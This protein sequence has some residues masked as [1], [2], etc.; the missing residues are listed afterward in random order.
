MLDD[1]HNGEPLLPGN[2]APG[3]LGMASAANGMITVI[4]NTLQ[5]VSCFT[6]LVPCDAELQQYMSHHLQLVKPWLHYKG[7]LLA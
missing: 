1:Q 4:H 2:L 3:P 5:L 7:R 6:A